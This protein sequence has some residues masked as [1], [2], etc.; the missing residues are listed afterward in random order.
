[1]H[2]HMYCIYVSKYVFLAVRLA[3]ILTNLHM[4]AVYIRA[5]AGRLMRPIAIV[6]VTICILSHAS[7][8]PLHRL[9][10]K[11]ASNL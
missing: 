4:Q 2:T 1:M 3:A 9:A 8:T 5:I 6:F 7:M 11:H 10:Y